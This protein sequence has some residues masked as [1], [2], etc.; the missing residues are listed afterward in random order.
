MKKL[1]LSS[2]AL[3]GLTAT[4]LAADL[5]RRTV[6]APAPVP[7]VAVPVFTWTGFY[8]GV[9]AGYGFSDRDDDDL[10][11]NGFGF[12]GFG[13]GLSV[14]T[15]AGLA[16]VVPLSG[17]NTFGLNGFNRRE[18]EGFV[19]GGQIGYN[20]QFTPGS[21]FVIG[22]EADIQ[23][24]DFNR[25]DDD[26]FFGFGGFGGFG[27]NNGIFTAAT[28]LPN[29]PGSGILPPTGVGNGALGNVA[30]FDGGLNSFNRF[31]R[32]NFDWFATVRGRLGYAFDRLLIYATGG[33]AFRDTD[34]GDDF[35]GFGFGTGIASGAALAG[36]GF[37]TTGAAAIA[38][39][40]VIPTNA[41]FFFDD[42]NRNDVGWTV[43]GGI[44]Y[45]FTGGFLG[46]NNVTAK[47]EGL[48]VN[49]EDD[50]RNNGFFGGGNVVGVSNTGA[51]VF[52]D[53]F[54]GS[55][56]NNDRNRDDFAVIRAGLNFKFGGL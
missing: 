34:N 56:F 20:F 17:F 50:R 37:Y 19:G 49:F 40:A 47:I 30:L 44:E 23:Y 45:A 27:S 1:L 29:G 6:V 5:P 16:P 11:N 25:R 3:L 38:G 35:N 22:L 7:F 54:A 10:F 18:R 46:F 4:A 42:R 9:N 28:V 36:T 21:G 32:H 48:Y 33:V 51:A 14:Q 8:V 53:Q 12:G 13:S 41:G 52:S 39:S 55:G 24:A 15:N 43:G 31:D 26:D 2:V